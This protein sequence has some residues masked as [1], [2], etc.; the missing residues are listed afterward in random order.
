MSSNPNGALM[1]LRHGLSLAP[2]ALKGS[3]RQHFARELPEPH[4]TRCGNTFCADFS[5]IEKLGGAARGNRLARRP[6]QHI[7]MST[8]AR[9]ADGASA[10][11]KGRRP[12]RPSGGRN[13]TR[14]SHPR[15]ATPIG[16]VKKWIPSVKPRTVMRST[17]R[18]RLHQPLVYH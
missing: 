18:D 3:P 17:A 8:S 7:A 12:M 5:T 15:M 13:G 1:R 10:F 16:T 11:G 2:A 14:G 9:P 4:Y 6:M